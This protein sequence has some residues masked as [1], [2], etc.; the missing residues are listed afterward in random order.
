MITSVQPFTSLKN[1][2]YIN[3]TTFRKT[4]EAVGTPLWF[5]E[6]QGILLFRCFLTG[7]E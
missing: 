7:N 3:L 2:K 4:G 6:Y 1:D 5:A